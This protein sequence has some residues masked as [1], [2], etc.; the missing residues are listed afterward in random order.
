MTEQE[1]EQHVQFLMSA[2][3]MSEAKARE[4]VERLAQRQSAQERAPAP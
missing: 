2:F 1:K 3:K 4:E